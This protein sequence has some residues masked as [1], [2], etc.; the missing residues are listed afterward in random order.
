M[1]N[2]ENDKACPVLGLSMELLSCDPGEKSGPQL[3]QQNPAGKKKKRNIT[4]FQ[5]FGPQGGADNYPGFS[6][7][8]E[9][10]TQNTTSLLMPCKIPSSIHTHTLWAACLLLH[11]LPTSVSS[12]PCWRHLC[13][14]EMPMQHGPWQRRHPS[15]WWMCTLEGLFLCAAHMRNTVWILQ[16]FPEFC[17]GYARKLEA[18][19]IFV[20]IS[21]TA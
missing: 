16:V 18:M 14:L 1:D 5:T 2:R 20:C 15:K 21:E 13:F 8:A 17:I 10:S 7:M 6:G 12:S 9:W 19:L 3:S 4:A 11:Q